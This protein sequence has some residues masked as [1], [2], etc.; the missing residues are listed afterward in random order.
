MCPPASRLVHVILLCIALALGGCASVHELRVDPALFPRPAPAAPAFDGRIALLTVPS[1]LQMT[2]L[3]EWLQEPPM[4]VA[5]VPIGRIVQ[6][7]SLAAFG[8]AFRGGARAVDAIASSPSSPMVT[9][10]LRVKHYAYRDRMLY[11]IPLGPLSMSRTQLDAQLEVALGL[12]EADGTIVWSA[13]YDSGIQVWEPP[14][15]ALGAP[16]ETRLEGLA[17]LTHEIAY[18]LMQQAARDVGEWLRNERL[19]ERPL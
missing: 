11:F 15:G 19:R 1:S 13:T 10:A 4:P 3:G 7:A 6:E 12:L 16:L 17:R 5:Q 9:V 14:R 18:R 8:A 2:V